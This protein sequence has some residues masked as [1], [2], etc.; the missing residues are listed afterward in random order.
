MRTRPSPLLL[1]RSLLRLGVAVLIPTWGACSESTAADGGPT[2]DAH[3]PQDSGLD[4]G[5]H[6]DAQPADAGADPNWDCVGHVTWST[7]TQ[8]TA[9]V[10]ITFATLTGAGVG[11]LLAGAQVEA[12]EG[13]DPL[14]PNPLD[15]KSTNIS[16]AAILQVPTGTTGFDGFFRVTTASTA[17]TYLFQHPPIAR[18]GVPWWGP[19]AV[20]DLQAI[21]ALAATATVTIDPTKGH[22][23]VL[24]ANCHY[25]DFPFVASHSTELSV[26]AAGR[27][28]DLSPDDDYF[29]MFFNLD[30]GPVA[31][32]VRRKSTDELVGRAVLFIV[33]GGFSETVLGPTPL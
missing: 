12:C 30:P 2:A 28:P 6:V 17:P 10:S 7:P 3:A 24:T 33:A 11:P 20:P 25:L 8:A 27:S 29:T 32:E 18:D 15:T 23:V 26:T 1:T 14:C 22:L 31:I 4:A 5:A 13:R 19:W 9:V 21:E 16:G